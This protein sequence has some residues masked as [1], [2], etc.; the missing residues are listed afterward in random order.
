[1]SA[2]VYNDPPL[3]LSTCSIPLHFSS[4]TMT[5]ESMDIDEKPEASGNTMA[6]LMVNARGKDKA[7]NGDGIENGNANGTMTASELKALNE[8]DGLPWSVPH[9]VSILSRS[10]V[11]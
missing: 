3:Y 6:T 2:S 7:S 10:I 11:C 1:M 9:E 4:I 5:E 8:R